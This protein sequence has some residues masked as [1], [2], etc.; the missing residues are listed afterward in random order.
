MDL[1]D[2][3]YPSAAVPTNDRLR[4]ELAR[5]IAKVEAAGFSVVPAPPPFFSFD[6]AGWTVTVMIRSNARG[7]GQSPVALRSAR[8]AAV[9]PEEAVNGLEEAIRKHIFD[10]KVAEGRERR[11]ARDARDE[12]RLIE[13]RVRR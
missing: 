4:S 1:A 7:R 13:G 3:L 11:D 12:D 5:A 6:D 8:S 10:T 9:G 2:L